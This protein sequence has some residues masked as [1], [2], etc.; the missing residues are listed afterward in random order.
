VIR[1]EPAAPGISSKVEPEAEWQALEDV[2][3]EGMRTSGPGLEAQAA[4][5]ELV[6]RRWARRRLR[7]AGLPGSGPNP[8]A[9]ARHF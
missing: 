9:L 2:A 7:L 8:K 6:R 3:T 5:I 1:D 4:L